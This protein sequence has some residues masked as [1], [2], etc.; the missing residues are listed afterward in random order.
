MVLSYTNWFV[1]SFGKIT[2]GSKVF[3]SSKSI[4]AYEMIMTM[5]P[6]ATLLA[7]G[8]LSAISPE[9]FFPGMTYVSNLSPL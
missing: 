9:P 3:A 5:S 8:P 2:V 4:F 1:I 6:F 7:A